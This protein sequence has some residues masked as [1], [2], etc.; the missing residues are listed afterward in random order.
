MDELQNLTVQSAPVPCF[1]GKWQEVIWAYW[2]QSLG[3][4]GRK[5]EVWFSLQNI[6]ES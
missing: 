6:L 1:D 2:V 4:Y 3:S 5:G